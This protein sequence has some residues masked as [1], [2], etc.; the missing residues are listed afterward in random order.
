[1]ED[2]LDQ[3]F[4]LNTNEKLFLPIFS[5]GVRCKGV[6]INFGLATYFIIH[7]AKFAYKI[8]KS[9]CKNTNF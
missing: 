3:V 4:I 1:M 8:K 7:Y 5:A 9:A 2:L 6:K